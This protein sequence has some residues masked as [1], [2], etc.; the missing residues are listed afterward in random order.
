[1]ASDRQVTIAL[2]GL[3]LVVLGLCIATAILGTDRMRLFVIAL[4]L[5][6]G[7]VYVKPRMP[8]IA[9]WIMWASP[10]TLLGILLTLDEPLF[11]SRSQQLVGAAFTLMAI[12]L[13][14]V[15]SRARPAA[16]PTAELPEAKL[17]R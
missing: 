5:P 14:F 4:G 1:M 13:P 6:S 7:W 15:R 2:R 3:V 12:G 10:I 17:R 11:H 8:Q 16:A 9:I